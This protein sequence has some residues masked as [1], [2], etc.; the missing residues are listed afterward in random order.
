MSFLFCL[1]NLWELGLEMHFITAASGAWKA[2]YH[3]SVLMKKV[4]IVALHIK[5]VKPRIE[6][7]MGPSWKRDTSHAV[8][9]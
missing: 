4:L 9:Q 8:E 7:K 6:V 2:C 1:F 5:G 3:L